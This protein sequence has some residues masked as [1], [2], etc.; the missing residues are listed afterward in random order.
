MEYY[1]IIGTDKGNSRRVIT[2]GIGPC[3]Y[4]Q[5]PEGKLRKEATRHGLRPDCDLEI[6]ELS[7]LIKHI[8]K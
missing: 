5:S 1:K 3:S 8:L 7:P 4:Y 2:I 6:E